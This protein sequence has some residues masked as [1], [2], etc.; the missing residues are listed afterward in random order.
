M[1]VSLSKLWELVMDREAC[2]A[3]VHE[4][5]KRRTWVSDWTELIYIAETGDIKVPCHLLK[6]YNKN[7][8]IA[9]IFTEN[10][11]PWPIVYK[12]ISKTTD[13]YYICEFV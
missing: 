7:D 1:G 12:I 2:C 9:V 3:A 6:D 11:E 13:N 8:M 5:A 10:G 4:M